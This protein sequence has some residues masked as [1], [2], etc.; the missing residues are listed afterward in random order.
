MTTFPDVHAALPGI[1]TALDERG[2][3]VI[4]APPGTGKTTRIPILLAGQE[5]CRR[6]GQVWVLEPR[7]IAARASA[8]FVARSIGESVGATIGYAVRFE[9]RESGSTRVMYVTEALL[10]RR[11][12]TDPSL[13]GQ[14]GPVHTVVLDEF[15]ERSIHTDLALARI[16]ALRARPV[17]L[18]G[19]PDLRLV[20]MSATLDAVGLARALDAPVIRV[21]AR[22]FPVELRPFARKDDRPLVEQVRAGVAAGLASLDRLPP[23]LNTV[24]V[25]LPGVGEI[26]RCTD[27]LGPDLA[28]L[29]ERVEL[30]PLH[31]ELDGGSQDRALGAC[32]SR[33]IILAT[34]VAE[35][36]V[37]VAGVGVVVDSGLA[38]VAGH[39]PWSG[40]PTLT[41]QP[42]SRAS[43]DQ[44]AGR[45][46]RLGP[47]VCWRLYSDYD[48]RPAALSPE[49]QRSEL[50]G[51]ALEVGSEDLPWLQP[52]PVA[53]WRAARALLVR[54]GGLTAEDRGDRTTI[55]EAMLGLPLAPRLARVLIE[56]AA[57]GAGEEAA[58]L[59]AVLGRSRAGRA[60]DPV[61]RVLDGTRLTGEA[62]QERR[63]LAALV[64]GPGRVPGGGGAQAD[65][66]AKLVLALLAGFPDR[67]GERKGGRVVFAE[68]GSAIVDPAT[69]GGDGF[70]VVPDAVSGD[71]GVRVRLLT[72]V[73]QDWLADRA[74]VRTTVRW[75]GTRV[76]V[77]E[78]L[79][80]G[81][82]VLDEGVATPASGSIEEGDVAAMLAAE[83]AP[84]AHRV[85]PD[86]ATAD[87][88]VGRITWL[89]R[90]GV[91][92]PEVSLDVVV[93]QAC[94]GSR[95]FADLGEVSLV[96]VIGRIV[97]L[98]RVDA[99]A[100]AA[101]PLGNRKRTPITYPPDQDPFIASRMQDFFGLSR[102]P[103]IA[104]DRP[105]VLHL[106]AP[107]QRPVQITGD[108][109]GFWKNHWPGIRKELMRRYPRQL[110]PDNP[111][112]A[113][114]PE[115]RE[116]RPRSG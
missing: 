92:L 75:A 112:E 74:D 32:S 25:F 34:N 11:F 101:I 59:V 22:R 28:R 93:R 54:L 86:H 105:L 73:P 82:L 62:E 14:S 87:A 21:E 2:V 109:A 41:V 9:R 18:G 79:R 91:D 97:D 58:A 35:T 60:E 33:R 103:L 13:L 8:A 46:G 98:V 37:T 29:P 80:F 63:Q 27:A 84:V 50:S 88:L 3:V 19:R 5:P 55:G 1:Q 45:A 64:R 111:L 95:S 113:E 89:R 81:E 17:E 83:V 104:G 107:N 15:H 102:S 48:Q 31:G 49:L 65:L 100:P 66:A 71:G 85:F 43:A 7:R 94:T 39:D 52:P 116:R 57:L 24:L 90:V 16:R 4:E 10:G 110:W 72:R 40:M 70:V 56:G 76:E 44:R 96:A 53:A 42:I 99:L 68:G 108:L 67:V 23:E 78:Q 30:V 26:E 106:L 38:R 12:L 51:L 69:P 115:F 114:P 36:S 47:G 61:A 20:I 77:R 6:P